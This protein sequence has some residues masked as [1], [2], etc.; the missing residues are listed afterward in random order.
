VTTLYFDLTD[1][2]DFAS[3]YSRVTGIQRV[4]MNIVTHLARRHGGERIRCTYFDARQRVMLEFDPTQLSANEEFDAEA[5]L[6]N[7]GITT[8]IAWLRGLSNSQIKSFLRRYNH[9]KWLRAIKKVEIYLAAVFMPRRL[10]A[11]GLSI[12]KGGAKGG[13]VVMLSEVES[14]PTASVYVC[15]GSIWR[16]RDVLAF[17]KRQGAQGGAVVQMVYDLIPVVHPEYYA[18]AEPREYSEWLQDA[19]GYVRGFMCISE[20]TAS[21][22]RG[23][24]ARFDRQ[25]KTRVV[26]LAHEFYGF[27]RGSRIPRPH[28]LADF[29]GKSFVLCV[30]TIETRKNGVSLLRAWRALAEEFGE[31]M[32]L[33]V[34]AGKYGKGG[35][36]VQKML[37]DD[38]LLARLV[39]LEHAPSDRQ[40]AWLYGNCLFTVFPS[41]YEGWGLPVGE[42]AW[43][44]KYCVASQATSIPEV[45]GELLGY[46]DP[47]D[48]ES[49]K[50]GIRA[51]LSSPDTLRSRERALEGAVLRSWAN[52]ADD[53]YAYL[54]GDTAAAD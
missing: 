51:M 49:V 53:I 7:L 33:L 24:A 28:E 16:Q 8:R 29:N 4:Q 17:A 46:V 3:R 1:V 27:E 32:P 22:L 15:M 34:F 35:E 26:P 39:R 11:I 47:S 38:V 40:L 10:D 14:L 20:W 19:F 52:V 30:G 21:D 45:C 23:Y 5:L 2:V 6:D 31:R 18:P 25:I 44:G 37:A 36:L 48:L 43:F 54:R 13:S 12:P 9:R 42:S 41:I 50:S